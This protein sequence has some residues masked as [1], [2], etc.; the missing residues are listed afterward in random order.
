MFLFWYIKIYICSYLEFI[1]LNLWDVKFF[2][3]GFCFVVL[4]W[5]GGEI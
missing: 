4:M 2:C 3:V 1:M 5:G